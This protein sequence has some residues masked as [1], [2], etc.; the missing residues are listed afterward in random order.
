M[1]NSAR[2]NMDDYIINP[3]VRVRST[4]SVCR[5]REGLTLGETANPEIVAF[6]LGLHLKK[7]RGFSLSREAF[8][9]LVA[10]GV[11][12]RKAD[13]PDEVSFRCELGERLPPLVP[14][15]SARNYDEEVRADELVL[16]PDLH[17]Q[18]GRTRPRALAERS[19]FL[20]GFADD[21]PDL[22]CDDPG[23]KILAPFWHRGAAPLDLPPRELTP[24]RLDLLRR[25]H[26][27]VGPD[28][29]R[30]RSSE[31]EARC[32]V[33]RAGLAREGFAVVRGVL[34]P[35]QLAAVRRYC[36]DLDEQGYLKHGD[37]HVPLRNVVIDDPVARFFHHQ[38]TPLLSRITPEPIKPSYSY[39]SVY[40]PGAVLERHRDRAPCAWN[41]SLVFDADPETDARNAWPIYVEANGRPR[42]VRLKIGDGLLYRGSAMW[43]WRHAQPKGRKTTVCFFHFVHR[44]YTGPLI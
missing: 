27:L 3:T 24:R 28:Y 30:R 12:A 41:F 19:R 34:N 6:L 14:Y 35:I 39:L 31:W 29:V 43:H 1:R 36:R 23:T 22:W 33:A 16:H 32:R 44:D 13:V 10:S 11:L 4:F 7:P 25:A 15:R 40:Q 5:R 9:H 20:E 37:A 8:E 17:L 26:I 21:G 38:I 42:R 18:R 2:V